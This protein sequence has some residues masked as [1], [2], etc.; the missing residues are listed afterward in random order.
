MVDG[1]EIHDSLAGLD[2]VFVVFTQA[3]GSP[4]PAEGALDDP[5]PLMDDEAALGGI[6][7][8]DLQFKVIPLANRLFQITTI[9]LVSPD[10]PQAG[11]A[12]SGLGEDQLSPVPIL[13]PR[14]MHDDD[15][16]KTEGVHQDVALASLDLF[17][18]R[19]SHGPRRLRWS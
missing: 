15:Q 8:H 13:E 9:G 6:G 12:V 17:S 18:P 7:A 2:E 4:E 16:Q 3:P 1:S 11:Q 14:R 5:A 10:L 19:P